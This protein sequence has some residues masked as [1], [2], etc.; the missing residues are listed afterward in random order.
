MIISGNIILPKQYCG[1]EQGRIPGGEQRGTPP[2]PHNCKRGEEK[3]KEKGEKREKNKL[4][5]PFYI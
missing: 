1:T 3:G 2:P 5:S 4:L